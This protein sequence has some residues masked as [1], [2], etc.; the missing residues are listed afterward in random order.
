MPGDD[1]D[2]PARYACR[3]CAH[4]GRCKELITQNPS[5]TSCGWSPSRFVVSISVA[6]HKR[7]ETE[8]ARLEQKVIERW[9]GPSEDERK[10]K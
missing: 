9:T 8:E 7:N 5:A 10:P 3:H 2:L 6:R 1:T 4:Y